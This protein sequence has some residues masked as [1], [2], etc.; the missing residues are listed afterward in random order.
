MLHSLEL[1]MLP[2][3]L[4]L[5]YV[6]ELILTLCAF[7][8]HTRVRR[9]SPFLDVDAL[10]MLARLSSCPRTTLA[11]FHYVASRAYASSSTLTST[12]AA[13]Y[14]GTEPSETNPRLLIL[15]LTLDI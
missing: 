9:D 11:H 12:S 14:D 10:I 3:T 15:T 7:A 13:P 1:S 8:H 6:F 2:L 4:N 5:T